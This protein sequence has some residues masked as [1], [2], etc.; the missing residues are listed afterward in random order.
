[1]RERGIHGAYAKLAVAPGGKALRE[2]ID[3]VRRTPA[4]RGCNLT[5]PH[6]IDV[7]AMLDEVDERARRIGA[8]NTVVRQADGRLHGRNTDAF[9]FIE[10]LRQSAP[11][12]RPAPGQWPSSAPVARHAR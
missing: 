2:A 3:F 7:L 10:H 1:L 4:A 8:V 6:K 9:G 5:L 11:G 12:W